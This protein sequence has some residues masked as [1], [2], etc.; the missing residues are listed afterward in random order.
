[1]IPA[2]NFVIS[3]DGK[4]AALPVDMV[5][6]SV[7]EL[8]QLGFSE[9]MSLD[10]KPNKRTGRLE[11]NVS[12]EDRQ[13]MMESLELGEDGEEI[14]EQDYFNDFLNDLIEEAPSKKEN[15]ALIKKLKVQKQIDDRKIALVYE[16]L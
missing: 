16:A 10:F 6:K 8:K 11:P 14:V 13:R 15:I 2:Q 7:A 4:P 12:P 5:N 3:T 1:M 9:V